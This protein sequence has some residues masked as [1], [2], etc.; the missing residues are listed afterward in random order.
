MIRAKSHTPDLDKTII[1][2][3]DSIQHK[4]TILILVSHILL[5]IPVLDKPTITWKIVWHPHSNH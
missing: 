5:S 1:F 3:A 4:M 2:P